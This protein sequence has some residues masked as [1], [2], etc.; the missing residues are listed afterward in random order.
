MENEEKMDNGKWT[1]KKKW[2]MENG[3]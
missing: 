1:M 3:K 2:K